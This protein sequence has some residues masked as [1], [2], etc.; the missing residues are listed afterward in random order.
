MVSYWKDLN[1]SYWEMWNHVGTGVNDFWGQNGVAQSL[2][3]GQRAAFRSAALHLLADGKLVTMERDYWNKRSGPVPA[4][5]TGVDAAYKRFVNYYG[6]LGD[7]VGRQ[8][9]T[10]SDYNAV[11][12]AMVKWLTHAN[13]M[14]A[15]LAQEKAA[16]KNTGLKY[17]PTIEY[18]QDICLA[19]NGSDVLMLGVLYEQVYQDSKAGRKQKMDKEINAISDRLAAIQKTYDEWTTRTAPTPLIAGSQGPATPSPVLANLQADFVAALKVWKPL[20]DDAVAARNSGDWATYFA[21]VKKLWMDSGRANDLVKE[22]QATSGQ[23]HLVIVGA[24]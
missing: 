20:A 23:V 3:G 12:A 4:E 18:W 9:K 15:V 8:M 17:D 5:L 6:K 1:N 7:T 11:R 16:A 13:L 10:A 21:D 19:F 2:S 22:F 24:L 14:Q